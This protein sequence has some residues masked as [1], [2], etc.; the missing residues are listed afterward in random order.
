MVT[1]RARAEHQLGLTERALRAE[2]Q[3]AAA[4]A[5][6]AARDAEVER[7]RENYRCAYEERAE[8][9]KEVNWLKDQ[10]AEARAALEPLISLIER[11]A[12]VLKQVGQ[13]PTQ[14]T[15]IIM[16]RAR[17]VVARTP[18]AGGNAHRFCSHGPGQPCHL[19]DQQASQPEQ[20]REG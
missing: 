5:T 6:I 14:E 11:Q 12:A 10:L 19:D 3:L 7:F 15:K 9:R 16:E 2:T 1:E 13:E 20:R 4:N 8:Y 17:A 18:E